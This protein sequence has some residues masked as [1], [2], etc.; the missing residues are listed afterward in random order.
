MDEL[1]T[2]EK[3]CGITL[4]A[5]YT[6]L[7]DGGCLDH[8]DSRYV[9]LHEAEWIPPIEIPTHKLQS[10]GDHVDG[11]VP[12][13]FSGAGDSWCWQ[14]NRPTSDNEYQIWFCW[15]DADH[16]DIYAP[17]FAG[18]IYRCCLG[19]ALSIDFETDDIDEARELLEGWS[20][21]LSSLQ[22]KEESDHLLALSRQEDG[23]F[24]DDERLR[25]IVQIRFGKE[26]CDNHIV[27]QSSGVTTEDNTA[28]LAAARQREAA[29]RRVERYGQVT[30]DA[31]EAFRRGDF[32][33]YVEILGPFH[34]MLTPA[35]EKKL[36]IAARKIGAGPD[37]TG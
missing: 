5:S 14:R 19:Y 25:E 28:A 36:S 23:E 17:T 32:S 26:Y 12:F 10:Y 16:A 3:A 31:D 20:K 21:L 9:W 11:L 15:H 33:T 7:Y 1:T 34:D 35:Q 2:I 27:W 37:K 22:E 18:W 4:P 24:I 30:N 6:Q 13:A 29:Q 8:R